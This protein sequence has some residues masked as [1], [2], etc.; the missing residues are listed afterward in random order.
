[1]SLEIPIPAAVSCVFLPGA[2]FHRLFPGHLGHLQDKL[3]TLEGTT[4]RHWMIIRLLVREW[5]S[6][7][8]SHCVLLQSKQVMP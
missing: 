6:S 3:I 4:G 7:S 8:P 1:M 2:M 5:F